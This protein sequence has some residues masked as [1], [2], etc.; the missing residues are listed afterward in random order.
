MAKWQNIKTKL[1]GSQGN[2]RPEEKK[3]YQ[4]TR[5][6]K[7]RLDNHL[8]LG[9]FDAICYLIF[10]SS[11]SSPKE[12]KEEKIKLI[13]LSVTSFALILHHQPSGNV[14]I[15]P[16]K[17]RNQVILPVTLKSQKVEKSLTRLDFL[18]HLKSNQMFL[19]IVTKTLQLL[20]KYWSQNRN[21]RN[22]PN[23]DKK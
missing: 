1:R 7:K 18:F 8:S 10:P 6:R 3:W 21:Q 11:S 5:Q 13:T 19:N 9:F 12:H 4:E 16:V 15:M 20:T 2:N 14:S 22:S 17:D 23:F